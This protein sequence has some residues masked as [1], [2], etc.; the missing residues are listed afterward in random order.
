ME[1][2]KFPG[3]FPQFPENPQ[4]KSLLIFI[5]FF[6]IE[7]LKIHVGFSKF[8]KKMKKRKSFYKFFVRH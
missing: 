6:I 5:D 4:K 8:E 3:N 1:I 2:K 7:K